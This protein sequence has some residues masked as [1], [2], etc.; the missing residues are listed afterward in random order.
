VETDYAH[1]QTFEDKIVKVNAT[2]YDGLSWGHHIGFGL[3]FKANDR[4][5]LFADL[6]YIN[7]QYRPKNLDIFESVQNYEK[8]TTDIIINQ[9]GIKLKDT[10]ST[11]DKGFLLFNANVGI[12]FTIQSLDKN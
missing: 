1:S 10:K 7:H 6:G 4:L 3:D 9:K 2:L 5:T 8:R 11:A 12:S